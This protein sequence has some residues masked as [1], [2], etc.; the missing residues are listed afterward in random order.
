[1]QPHIAAGNRC[2]SLEN[3]NLNSRCFYHPLHGQDLGHEAIELVKY[4]RRVE[5][6]A[7]F[8][9]PNCPGN[10]LYGVTPWN[11]AEQVMVARG[12]EELGLHGAGTD[13]CDG[14]ALGPQLVGDAA[15]KGGDIRLGGAVD[16]HAGRRAESRDGRDVDDL[17]PARHKWN[18]CLRDHG[19]RTDIEV[20]DTHNIC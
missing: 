14:N 19:Q 4:G 13:G 20:N 12:I 11:I 9:R 2:G 10:N 15:G 1:M 7:L 5:R 16:R 6:P 18:N 8:R 17:R 3:S